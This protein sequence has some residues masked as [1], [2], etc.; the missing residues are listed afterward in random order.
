MATTHAIWIRRFIKDM[1]L[2]FVDE[3]IEIY[4][5]N[6]AAIS[7]INSGANSSCGK[8]IEIQYH[9][10]R[11]IVQKWEVKISYIPTSDMIADP[12]TKSLSAENFIKHVGL[13]GLRNI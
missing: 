8:H 6:Q 7:L 3:P 1:D 5:D 9:Y 13:M 10:I 4:C 2:N 11:D 12:L